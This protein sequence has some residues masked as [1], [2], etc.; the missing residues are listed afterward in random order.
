M[1]FF[2][3]LGTDNKTQGNVSTGINSLFYFINKHFCKKDKAELGT[4]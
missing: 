3:Y 2:Q 1:K 4:F